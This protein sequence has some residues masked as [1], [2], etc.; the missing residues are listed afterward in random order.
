MIKRSAKVNLQCIISAGPYEM[1]FT[2]PHGFSFNWRIINPIYRSLI[3]IFIFVTSLSC[4]KINY[5]KPME[6]I[7]LKFSTL[8]EEQ[9]FWNNWI[10]NNDDETCPLEPFLLVLTKEQIQKLDKQLA[11]TIIESNRFMII[12]TVN[13]QN[14]IFTI[15]A[16]TENKE[17]SLTRSI[18]WFKENGKISINESFLEKKFIPNTKDMNFLSKKD[19]FVSATDRNVFDASSTYV[20]LFDGYKYNKFAFYNL[21]FSIKELNSNSYPILV[22]DKILGKWG[23]IGEKK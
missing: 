5:M 7:D 13:I 1:K 21:E 10:K 4:S 15:H 16:L 3:T 23:G 18:E 11:E 9:F 20:T 22:L 14:G 6:T 2:K 17:N 12:I 8:E 19:V